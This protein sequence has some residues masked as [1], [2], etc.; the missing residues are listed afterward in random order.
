MVVKN[1]GKVVW[2]HWIRWWR[3][4]NSRT[5]RHYGKCTFSMNGITSNNFQNLFTKWVPIK[6]TDT[7]EWEKGGVRDE[8][9]KNKNV[10]RLITNRHIV[11]TLLFTNTRTNEKD[12]VMDWN[13]N[14][15]QV[16]FSI[17]Y[18]DGVVVVA[19]EL[20]RKV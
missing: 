18:I 10:E 1:N 13:S 4:S 2:W 8:R 17:N 3:L 12:P 9:K 5:R 19:R 11:F 14:R 6:T 15:W 16:Y 20:I 7:G